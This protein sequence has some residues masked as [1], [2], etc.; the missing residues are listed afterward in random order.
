MSCGKE[1][2]TN[3]MFQVRVKVDG[4]INRSL[5]LK[6]SRESWEQLAIERSCDRWVHWA[7][8]KWRLL[9]IASREVSDIH[10]T[11]LVRLSWFPSFSFDAPNSPWGVWNEDGH[12]SLRFL[13]FQAIFRGCRPKDCR[14]YEASE[15]RLR[16]RSFY[17]AG[18]AHTAGTMPSC[19]VPSVDCERMGDQPAHS[20]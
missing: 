7:P 8:K 12:P 16:V 1:A 19:R 3:S 18:D 9:C 13:N 6:D 11:S 4:A 15:V 2:R 5:D 10:Q 17:P 14:C 20:C